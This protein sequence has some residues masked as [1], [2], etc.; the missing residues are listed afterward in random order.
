MIHD[1]HTTSR[2]ELNVEKIN[3]VVTIYHSTTWKLADEVS[4][5]IKTA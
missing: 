1:Q 2:T 4:M 5:N 3:K